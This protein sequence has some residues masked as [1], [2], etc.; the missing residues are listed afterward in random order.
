MKMLF[1]CLMRYIGSVHCFCGLKNLILNGSGLQIQTS[2]TQ[3]NIRGV[4]QRH[5]M[6]HPP[7]LVKV[8]SNLAMENLLGI[9]LHTI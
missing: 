5:G 1:Y 2:D 7:G 6:E 8:K 9:V 3:P 4:G